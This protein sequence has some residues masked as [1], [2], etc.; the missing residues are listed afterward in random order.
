MLISSVIAYRNFSDHIISICSGL[1]CAVGSGRSSSAFSSRSAILG[2]SEIVDHLRV[3]LFN[4]LWLGT[5]SVTTATSAAAAATTTGSGTIGL[6]GSSWL[7]LRLRLTVKVSKK[8]E[9]V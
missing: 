7:R 3:E 1:S 9:T 2:S 8:L 6:G 5:V 4:G